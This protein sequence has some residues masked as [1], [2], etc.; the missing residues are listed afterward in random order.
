MLRYR[1]E[2]S[3]LLIRATSAKKLPISRHEQFSVEAV[4]NLLPTQN[5]ELRARAGLMRFTFYTTLWLP[6]MATA[7][8][9]KQL[10]VPNVAE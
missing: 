2:T 9:V 5:H 6:A 3:S 8:T 1:S 4:K 10:A 7:Q